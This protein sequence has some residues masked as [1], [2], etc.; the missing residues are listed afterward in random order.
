M[1]YFLFPKSAGKCSSVSGNQPDLTESLTPNSTY[2]S[3]E[4]SSRLS[5][6]VSCTGYIRLLFSVRDGQWKE[7]NDA[8]TVSL[9]SLDH[10]EM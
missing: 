2:S 3:E 7:R 9:V 8:D 6:F 4:T 5:D 10:K 1:A